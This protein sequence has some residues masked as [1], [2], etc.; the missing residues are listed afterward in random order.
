MNSLLSISSVSKSFGKHR[1]L[2]QVSLALDRGQVHAVVGESG[3]GKTTLLR[4]IAGLTESDDGS[5]VLDGED[6]TYRPAEKRCIGLVFQDYALFPHLTV[7]KNITYGIS[8][9]SRAEREKRVT[10]LLEMIHLPGIGKRYPHELSGG[11]QQRVALA[12]ALAQRPSLLLLD[13]PFSNLDSIRRHKL[14][15]VVREL[16]DQLH[17][18][19]L[20][21]THDIDD[22]FRVADTVTI[23]KEG[24]VVQSGSPEDIEQNPVDDYVAELI[25]R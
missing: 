18:A 8:E 12:R 16:A 1:V 7:I 2:Q 19:S 22:A 4:I 11:Q 17:T 10:E 13:E 9:L 20:I 23:L 25:D 6:I 21:V 14:R 15:G 5:V 24:E 3:C